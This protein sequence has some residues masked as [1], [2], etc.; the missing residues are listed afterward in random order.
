M[1]HSQVRIRQTRVET[2]FKLQKTG[3]MPNGL[4]YDEGRD[5]LLVSDQGDGAL[6]TVAGPGSPDRRE[7]IFAAGANKPSGLVRCQWQG[8]DTIFI[9]GTYGLDLTVIQGERVFAISHRGVGTGIVDFAQ[10]LVNG[11]HTGFHGLEWDGEFL[12]GASPPGK[13][14]FKMKLED[15]P[16]G[17]AI[18]SAS[19]FAV[20]AGNRPHGLAWANP[21][22]TELW[23]NDTTIGAVY[24]YDT[25]T[26]TCLEVLVLPPDAPKAHG[27]TLVRG[28]LWY[29][30]DNTALFCKII[31]LN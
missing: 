16:G 22:C 26:G 24:R 30:E 31:P 29:C 8:K 14:L 5:E 1:F 17:P 19:W 15:T 11:T 18:T 4:D 6:I 25:R 10:D 7:T 3:A 20:A 12:W 23:C 21:Q 13:A 9:A 2:L 27:M 28:D